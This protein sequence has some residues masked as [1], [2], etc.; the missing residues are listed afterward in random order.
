MLI[1]HPQKLCDAYD[2]ADP[3]IDTI[4]RERLRIMPSFQRKQWEFALIYHALDSNGALHPEARGIAFGA[5]RERLVYALSE[6]VE[7]LLATD[8]YG[9]GAAWVGART[10]APKE[11]LLDAAPFPV[12][13]ARIDA[14]RLDMRTV[15]YD[16]PP[17][18]F[19]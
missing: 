12:D 10:N 3:R 15:E 8:L 2:W 13:P 7:H 6:R 5:G 14:A 11:F 17:V 18:D 4:L 19:C 16:G 9:G 1:E